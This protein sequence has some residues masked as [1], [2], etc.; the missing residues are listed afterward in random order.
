MGDILTSDGLNAFLP[1]PPD[2]VEQVGL[3]G[4]AQIV[5]LALIG[6][7]QGGHHGRPIHLGD[8]LHEMLEEVHDPLAPDLAQS[9]L[10]PRVHQHFVHQN[11]CAESLLPGERKKLDQQ[12][13]GGG[14]SR[15]SSLPSACSARSPSAP[16][17]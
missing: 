5:V 2:D 14:V 10:A 3:Q 8:G 6:S 9:R 16:A 15:S 11:Q 1:L 13:F 7:E 12:R 17:S 4:L